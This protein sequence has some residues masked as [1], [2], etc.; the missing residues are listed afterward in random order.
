MDDRKQSVRRLVVELTVSVAHKLDDLVRLEELN[1]TTIVNRALLLY[2]MIVELQ[3]DGGK[4]YI[5]EA[6]AQ[7]L[8][9]LTLL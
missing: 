7:E 5:Q 9:R 8:Q 2:G 6:G 3:H 1:K 4:V